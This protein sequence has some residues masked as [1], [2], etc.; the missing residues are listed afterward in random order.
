MK[1]RRGRQPGGSAESP[2]FCMVKYI[3]PPAPRAYN[4]SVDFIALR[5]EDGMSDFKKTETQGETCVLPA[6]DG[7]RHLFPSENSCDTGTGSG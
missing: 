3:A 4:R 5:P 7:S 1:W 6:A 2:C